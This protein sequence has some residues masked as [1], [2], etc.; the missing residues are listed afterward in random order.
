MLKA[1][2]EQ[3]K[4]LKPEDMDR[5]M[6]EMDSMGP[7][8]KAAL[9]AMGM[10]PD[11]MMR[12]MKMMRDNPQMAESARKMMSNMT[13]Q[14]LMEQSKLAQEQMASMDVN[15]V[16]AATKAMESLSPEQL[17][18]AAD[19]IKERGLPT[20]MA[21]DEP[22][23]LDTMYRTAEM[24]TR[25]PTGGVSL[26]A[27]ATLPPIT[28]LSGTRDEDLSQEELEECWAEGTQGK[29]RADRAA[30][31]R[32]WKEVQEYFEGDIMEEAR[33]TASKRSMKGGAPATSSGST[34][35]SSPTVGANLSAD[36]MAAMNARVKEM[37][38]DDVGA[39]LEQMSNL[40]PD[41][42]ARMKSMGADPA[43]MAKAAKMMSSNPM[44]KKAAANLMKNM[45]PQDMM[46]AS[47][48]AQ[49]QM[50]GMTEE[51]RRQA[52]ENIE[53]LNGQSK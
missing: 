22:L 30:F 40:T 45:S 53:K 16:E 2:A 9:K 1:S 23:V 19:L 7:A 47:Q 5:M 43:M 33:K 28:V 14:E 3:M 26:Q 24:M 34:G 37:S 20:Q 38:E 44:M 39:M 13:P 27:F 31:E 35:T 46:K 32:V 41:Q 49:E 52:L 12:S 11:L 51:E 36:E 21:S 4:N 17:D 15:D 29:I 48:Q 25:P 10:E 50:K 18:A 8:Q 42:E 6:A